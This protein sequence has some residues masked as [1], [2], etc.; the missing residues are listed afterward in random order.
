LVPVN[1]AVLDDRA[2][3]VVQSTDLA[4][5]D[6]LVSGDDPF[7]LAIYLWTMRLHDLTLVNGDSLSSWGAN[8]VHRILVDRNIGRRQD[9]EIVSATLTAAALIGTDTVAGELDQFRTAVSAVLVPELDRSLIPFRR[10]SYAAAFLFAATTIGVDEPRIRQAA[11]AVGSAFANAVPGGR[12]FGLDFAI[13][14]LRDQQL[15]GELDA[16]QRAITD[17]LANPRTDY[18]DKVYLL[19]ALWQVQDPEQPTE[20]V[21]RQTNDLLDRSPGWLSIMVALEEV[22]PAGDGTVAVNLSH[23]FRAAL[24]DVALQLRSAARSYAEKEIDK[25]YRGRSFVGLGAFGFSL[26]VLALPWIA[27]GRWILPLAVPAKEFWLLNQ[28]DALPAALAIEVMAAVLFVSF[29]GPFT[30]GM[31]WTLWPLLV[32]SRVESDH[33]IAEMLVRR[34]R[35]VLMWWLVIVF[36]TVTIGFS[37]G[38]FAPALQHALSGK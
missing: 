32:M 14:A 35:Q 21:V 18:E 6:L 7:A 16:L 30:V 15:N 10:L 34:I 13:R 31:I 5:R 28:Y 8:W 25:R 11:Q 22:H 27:L 12:L 36:L 2:S 26:I 4:I 20:G 23:L 24:L 9:E 38:V 33:R 17:A 29:L 3:T 19:Q 1:P 37:T